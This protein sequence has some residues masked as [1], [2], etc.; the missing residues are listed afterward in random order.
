MT[1]PI[2]DVIQHT[3]QLYE[4]RLTFAGQDIAGELGNNSIDACLKEALRSLP[5]T[6]LWVELRYNAVHMGTYF[7]D[8]LQHT[9]SEVAGRSAKLYRAVAESQ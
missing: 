4:W 6:W 5:E 9:I 3:R 7:A 1:Q 2:I 8:E